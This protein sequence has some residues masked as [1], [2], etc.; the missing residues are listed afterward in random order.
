MKIR[1]LLAA[2]AAVLAGLALP[3]TAIASSSSSTAHHPSAARHACTRHGNGKCVKR[4]QRC[5]KNLR[6]HSAYDNHGRRNVCKGKHPH[7]RKPAAHMCRVTGSSAATSGCVIVPTCTKNP[8]GS[9][10]QSGDPCTTDE[11]GDYGYDAEL[12]PLTCQ[13]DQNDPHWG[14]TPPTPSA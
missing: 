2:L 5:A 7:W 12:E 4:G 14:T 9:C 11:Y 13:G 1:I 10:I 3:G 8:D 6:G